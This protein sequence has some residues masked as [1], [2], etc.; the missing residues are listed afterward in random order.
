MFCFNILS[1]SLGHKN[2]YLK[3]TLF[4]KFGLILLWNLAKK[5]LLNFQP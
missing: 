5:T 4:C 3:V 1:Y 2:A